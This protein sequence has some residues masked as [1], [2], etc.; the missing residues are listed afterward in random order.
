MSDTAIKQSNT[1]FRELAEKLDKFDTDRKWLDLSPEDL[2][3]SIM[4]EGAEL[5]EHFQW[6]D[7]LRH[8]GGK[9]L[10]KD[11]AEVSNEVADILIYLLKFC[12]EMNIDIVEATLKK[13]DKVGA[14]YPA[15]YNKNSG[16]DLGHEEYLRL[17]KEHRAKNK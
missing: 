8:R 16:K 17:K 10:A 6:D 9:V 7:T 3:K 14:K 1:T 11:S 5:L 13:L 4:I 12:R 2:A 15:G